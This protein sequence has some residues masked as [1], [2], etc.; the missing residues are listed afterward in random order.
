MSFYKFKDYS[1]L[2][3]M[4]L[5]QCEFLSE[6]NITAEDIIRPIE[7]LF[8]QEV[9]DIYISE[10]IISSL[11]SGLGKVKDF[12]TN[13]GKAVSNF[14]KNFS[15]S[16]L[17]SSI[18]DSI[19]KW[20]AKVIQNIKKSLKSLSV[21]AL[22]NGL[23]SEDNKP[24]FKV[25]WSHIIKKVKEANLIT[26]DSGIK[27]EDLSKV[28]GNVV[29]KE[30]M[31]LE[32][33][34]DISDSEVKYYG[35]FEKVAHA[36][37]IKNARF[38]GVVSQIMK[39][40]TYGVVIMGIFKM[41]GFSVGGAIAGLGLG[42][43]AMGIIGGMLLMAGLIILTIWLCK[44]YPTLNDCLAYLQMAFGGNLTSN[45]YTN[46]F[47]QNIDIVY[48]QN[49]TVI[50]Y[51]QQNNVDVDSNVTNNNKSSND[52]DDNKDTNKS[53]TGVYSL[54]IRNLKALQSMIVTYRG[55]S[56][57][58]Q[59]GS[60]E[61]KEY[62]E[63]SKKELDKR[64]LKVG[65]TY[66]YTN[67]K[68][69]TKKVKLI[70]LTHD[71][72]PGKDK[73]WL[74]D[75]DKKEGELDPKYVSVIYPDKDGKYSSKSPEIAVAADGL[76]PFKEELSIFRFEDMFLLEKE[77][78]KGSRNTMIGKEDSYSTQALKNIR[79][80]ITYFLEDRVK[81]DKDST[82]KEIID[83]KMSNKE[84]VKK[85][86]SN[87]NEYL[88]GKYSKTLSTPG[89]LFKESFISDSK[90]NLILAEK[91]ARLYKRTEQL[92]ESVD[93]YGAMGEFGQD[94]KEFNETMEKIME[95]IKK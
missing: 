55:V 36:M 60:Q 95:S 59:G 32:S 52:K 31:I 62:G 20:G 71:M 10:G 86:Y 80:S 25:I 92:K 16:K 56:L 3:E 35:F 40:G 51:I 76:K 15:L 1:A 7:N 29:L 78:S 65:K 45:Y 43:V 75:D 18:T 83:D 46:I 44:P 13:I 84:D 21:Y 5:N 79:K 2:Y 69:V 61:E 57:E 19:K 49:T 22:K 89:S 87:I 85:L 11:K 73:Q 68:G 58:G 53:T 30:S 77:F 88:F 8:T 37:G 4:R 90:Q 34:N 38:N 6:Q 39:K 23:V 91:M 9:V 48:Q 14:F 70:S 33:E 26:P 74:T 41:I 66:Y 54:M 67:K 27:D 82:I 12:F 93:L 47:I 94:L 42:P 28:G 81:I 64:A 17:T 50:N 63:R 72:N 24:N